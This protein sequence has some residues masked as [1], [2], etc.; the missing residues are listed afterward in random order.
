TLPA[1]L[2]HGEFYASN[3]LIE[4]KGA[5]CRVAPVDWEMAAWGTGL[6]DLAALTAGN[7]RDEDRT[8]LALTYRAH[9]S[10]TERW[11][12]P[13]D[14]FLLAFDCCRVCLAVQWLGWSAN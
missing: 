10:D 14:E 6:L 7:W 13:L 11:N 12:P 2:L 4:S 3:I 8:A 1:T 5:R 9:W